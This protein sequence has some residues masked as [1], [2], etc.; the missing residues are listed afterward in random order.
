LLSRIP[1]L[2]SLALSLAL[3]PS[4]ICNPLQKCN[5]ELEARVGIG[6]FPACFRAKFTQFRKVLKQY[7]LLLASTEP[8]LAADVFADSDF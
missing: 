2:I 7:L 6:L 8:T 4:G 5:L 3:A 1:V